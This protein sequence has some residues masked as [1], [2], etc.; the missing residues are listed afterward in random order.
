MEK[1]IS[2]IQEVDKLKHVLRIN[3]LS[4][5]SRREN[6]AEHSWHLSLMVMTLSDY[7]EGLIDIT[8]A[9]KIAIIH[10]IVEIDAGDTYAFDTEGHKDKH[11]REQK[12]AKRLFG[13]LPPEQEK[14][15]RD[16]WEEYE[17]TKT[18]ESRFVAA[19][20]RL[21][22]FMQ[23]MGNRGL[24]WKEKK[25]SRSKLMT[26]MKDVEDYCPK[27]QKFMHSQIQK[28]IDN[29]WLLKD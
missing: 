8:R 1:Q 19:L 29:G 6:T 2:F 13:L 12:A 28:A 7:A 22:P 18:N 14:E 21:N 23:H 10:D 16:L 26:R 17:E 5:G 9:L 15:Y 3:R 27:L 25:M 11:E 20:D 4:D 24:T